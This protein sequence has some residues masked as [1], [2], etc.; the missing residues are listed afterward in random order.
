MASAPEGATSSLMSGEVK[1]AGVT[2]SDSTLEAPGSGDDNWY[3]KDSEWDYDSDSSCHWEC[4]CS[5]PSSRHGSSCIHHDLDSDLRGLDGTFPVAGAG[6][7][8]GPEYYCRSREPPSAF[9]VAHSHSVAPSLL[10]APQETSP[11]APLVALVP[12]APT[13][14]R[15]LAVA[16]RT[17]EAL[18]DNVA[19]LGSLF[20]KG[21]R[22]VGLE[23]EVCTADLKP[24]TSRPPVSHASSAI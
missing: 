3:V 18:T 20:L 11:S 5:H 16:R 10:A 2:M 7:T 19:V 24:S 13:G 14:P 15:A 9:P 8:V 6:A 22:S 12:G 1:S 21:P 17:V 4:L 23:S